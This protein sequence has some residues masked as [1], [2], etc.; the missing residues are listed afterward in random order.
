[1]EW[2]LFA[3]FLCANCFWEHALESQNMKI[4]WLKLKM[5]LSNEEQ[6]HSSLSCFSFWADWGSLL[7]GICLFSRTKISPLRP[8]TGLVSHAEPVQLL[9]WVI[10]FAVG[11]STGSLLTPESL[12]DARSIKNVLKLS[13]E[14]CRKSFAGYD[15][16]WPLSFRSH[17]N[18]EVTRHV[19]CSKQKRAT[20]KIKGIRH[21]HVL[22]EE[23]QFLRYSTEEFH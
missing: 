14:A 4:D 12:W 5:I 8:L 15:R 23:K 21:E 16:S 11:Q 20:R 22:Q 17:E 3:W 9:F 13:P 2:Q 10:C 6:V 19:T 7:C 18:I 1:M